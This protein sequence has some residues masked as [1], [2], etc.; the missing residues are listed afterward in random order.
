ML[1]FEKSV[2]GR[3]A[4]SGPIAEKFSSKYA[5]AFLLRKNNP[6]LPEIS[7]LD[8][9]RHFTGLSAENFGVDSG[10][11]P[12][13]S[14]TMKYNP[15][16]TEKIARLADFTD[17]HPLAGSEALQGIMQ[18][19]H[20]FSLFLSEL[21]GM[22]AF[23]LLPCAGA[24][25]EYT[26]L[27][28]IKKYFEKK[29]DDK[30]TVMLVP[31]SAHG[32]NPSSAHIAGFSIQQIKSK[33]NGEIDLED[34]KQHCS[35]DTAGIMLTNPNTLGIFESSILE[36]AE[37]VHK[38]GGLL[39]Y[40]G[41][42]ANAIMGKARIGDMG[43]DV[44]HLNLHKTFST[45]HGMG[46]PGSGPVGVSAA[47]KDFL[48]NPGIIKKNGKFHF[49][50]NK[51]S[52]GHVH[53]ALGNALVVV[54][55][56]YYARLLGKN[57]LKNVSEIAVLNANWL[58]K[59]LCSLLEKP[60]KNSVLHEFVLSARALKESHGISAYNIAKMLLDKNMHAPTIYFPL[61]V[62]EAIMIEPTETESLTT[63]KNF[64]RIM[65]EVIDEAKKNPEHAQHAPYNY[66]VQGI[67]EALA[68]RKPVTCFKNI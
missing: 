44:C 38:A 67:D 26:G 20:D 28:I 61:I 52:I 4:Y 46:G 43:F 1:L 66:S 36:I 13:G 30:R 65:H 22:A 9:L 45:P 51:Q 55:A 64:V 6:A 32:T 47:L 54:K 8:L 7:E 50:D 18:I 35:S 34:L 17:T 62:K 49:T 2:S 37:I 10:F 63:L 42:N 31:D 68:A 16:I 19:Y 25:G 3:R 24:H 53:Y 15:K 12:L 40:D 60:V 14:C 56:W 48:P 23:T 29:G 41:A 27:K 57:G 5:P 21:F 11:Y 39:Y 33:E 59:K 58:A